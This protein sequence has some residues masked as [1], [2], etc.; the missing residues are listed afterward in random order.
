M[1]KPTI[2]FIIA[3]VILISGLFAFKSSGAEK[4]DH[5]A[6]YYSGRDIT[7]SYSNGTF[8]NIPAQKGQGICDQTQMLK[9]INDIESEGFK[10]VSYDVKY[11]AGN[12]ILFA[13]N[14][15][16]SKQ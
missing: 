14:A 12:S 15:L 2:L 10:L 5:V 9:V 6:I 3:L 8:K 16:L 13:A 1:T 7:V 11:P 4:K